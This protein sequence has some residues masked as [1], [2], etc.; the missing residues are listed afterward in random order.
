MSLCLSSDLNERS[1]YLGYGQISVAYII[2][3]VCSTHSRRALDSKILVFFS[4]FRAQRGDESGSSLT[5]SFFTNEYIGPYTDECLHERVSRPLK[6]GC[7]S[8]QRGEAGQG[9]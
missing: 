2:R 5:F 8:I 4:S 1:G 6:G 3:A 7:I 9:G